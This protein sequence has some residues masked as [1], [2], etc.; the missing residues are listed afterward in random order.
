ML[1]LKVLF[2]ID[3]RVILIIFLLNAA[4]LITISAFS[5]DFL[6]SGEE[7]PLVNAAVKNQLQWFLISWGVFFIAAML[8][9]HTLREWTWVLYIVSLLGLVGLF[10]TDPIVRVQRWYKIPGLGMSFQPSEYAKLAMLFAL[11]WFME[12]HSTTARSFSTFIQA[13]LIAGIPFFLILKQ[14]DLGTA[15]I[16]YPMAVV[17]LY[18]GGISTRLIQFLLLPLLI[19]LLFIF[20]TFSGIVPYDSLR[21]CVR[22]VLKEYQYERLN[23]DTH[24]G[25]AAQMSLALGGVH[26]S[27]WKQGEFW[28]GGGL[29]APYTDSIFSAFGEEF[30]LVGMGL[31]LSVY[32]FL[33]YTCFQAAASAKDI[34]GR[35]I[36]AGVATSLAVHVIVNIG[37]MSG[38]LPITGVPLPLMSYGGSS[39]LATMA[40]LGVVQ[41]IYA[42]RFMF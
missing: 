15:L 8:D 1:N 18:F 27:G 12:K 5:P 28:R 41:S 11:A 6:T 14:P 4:S 25:K 34:F 31:L 7:M 32:Y 2:R 42:R 30:G 35:L 24:H 39:Y 19:S 3:F 33:I 9:Y 20:A 26:G 21:P 10:F 40:G 22:G 16:F 37:M 29:P 36:A 17:M 38:C 13:A 23:P